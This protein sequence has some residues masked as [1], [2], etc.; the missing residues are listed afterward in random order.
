MARKRKR[1]AERK[2]GSVS[3]LLSVLGPSGWALPGQW[4]CERRRRILQV[5][6][7]SRRD[8]VGVRQRESSQW[9]SRRRG[10]VHWRF[11]WIGGDGSFAICPL[12]A[13][14][15]ASP[16]TADCAPHPPCQRTASD[17]RRQCKL[18]DLKKGKPQREGIKVRGAPYLHLRQASAP[19]G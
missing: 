12:C 13:T 4:G 19:T 16:Q 6:G 15:R 18:P 17:G 9:P 5:K 14:R 2:E 11:C 1:G 3:L 10:V 8:C 7:F